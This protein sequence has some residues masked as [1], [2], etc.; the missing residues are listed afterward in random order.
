MFETK[1][2]KDKA[3][4]IHPVVDYK[5]KGHKLKRSS[6]SHLQETQTLAE[7]INLTIQMAA[8]VHLPK[9]TPSTYI[10]KGKVKELQ[11]FVAANDT[12]VCIIDAQISPIQQRNLEMALKTKVIDRTAL[13][14]EIFGE[15]ARTKEGVLQV[16][17]A[18]LTYQKSRLVR[19][20]THLE[21]QR[22]GFGFLGGPGERQIESDRRVINDRIT[23][24]KKQLEK[25][26]KMRDLHRKS[27]KKI[28]YPIVSL[29]GYTNAGKS[30]LFNTLTGDNVFA[31]DILFATLD[32]TM[33]LISL[34]SGKKVIISDTV[35]FISNLPTELIAAFRATLEEVVEADIILHVRDISNP[36]CEE[37][38][39]DVIEV[40]ENLNISE[41]ETKII[42]VFNKIDL[43]QN[44]STENNNRY[45]EVSA[46]TGEGTETLLNKLGEVISEDNVTL[47]LKVKANNGK[48]L[49]WIH[50]HAEVLEQKIKKETIT[51]TISISEKNKGKLEKIKAEETNR[52]I[53]S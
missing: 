27:R 49:A 51:L 35:G 13:I 21:R 24:I 2:P 5:E 53:K 9:I 46:L 23:S 50:A 10:G 8:T 39:Q 47:T 26:V 19:S 11:E 33:R 29:V 1:K 30:T 22:G 7:G 18:S 43:V 48:F 14:L 32:P 16:E 17:L 41:T 42:E 12:T 28:P 6:K 31:E 25:V 15:R 36:E 52:Q 4:I 3:I 34:P 44:H 37:Q 45:I 40:F 20:W 38:K